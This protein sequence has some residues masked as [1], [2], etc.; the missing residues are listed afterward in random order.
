VQYDRIDRGFI[1]SPANWVPPATNPAG[2]RGL[3]VFTNPVAATTNNFWRARS[4]P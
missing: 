4:V 3:A 2:F 1:L